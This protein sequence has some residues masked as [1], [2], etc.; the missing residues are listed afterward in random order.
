MWSVWW[1]WVVGAIVLGIV[2]VFVPAFIFLGFAIGAAVTGILMAVGG[3]LATFMMG[4]LPVTVLIFSVVSLVSWLMLRRVMG[5][6]KGQSKVFT[7][8]IN[9]D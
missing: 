8:D 5:V 6:R 2:E 9:E 7:T 1:I 3:P 4:S